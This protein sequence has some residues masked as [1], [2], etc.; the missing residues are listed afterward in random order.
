MSSTRG[1]KKVDG[2]TSTSFRQGKSEDLVVVEFKIIEQEKSSMHAQPVSNDKAQRS[3][4]HDSVR[5]KVM[6]TLCTSSH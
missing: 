5:L 6:D 3:M 4:I 2:E 1:F